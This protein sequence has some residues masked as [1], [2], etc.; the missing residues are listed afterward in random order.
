M[1]YLLLFEQYENADEYDI[2]GFMKLYD[3]YVDRYGKSKTQIGEIIR[4]MNRVIYAFYAKR[5]LVN[6]YSNSQNK[7]LTGTAINYVQSSIKPYNVELANDIDELINDKKYEYV[8]AYEDKLLQIVDKFTACLYEHEQKLNV[9]NNL[10]S[11]AGCKHPETNFDLR[12]IN[13]QELNQEF[14]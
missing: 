6:A 9:P 8:Q 3:R 2:S 11:L 14:F 1:K 7:N 13:D 5:V 12:Y 10:D 4:A